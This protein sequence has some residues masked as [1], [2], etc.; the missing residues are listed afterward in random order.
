MATIPCSEDLI[1]WSDGTHCYRYE[2]AEYTFM[3]DD[4]TIIPFD[5]HS[6]VETDAFAHDF[7]AKQSVAFA[8]V[9]V[10]TN[11]Q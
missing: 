8:A 10:P 11:L 3:S 1:V 4:F 7:A 2:L 6:H 9:F 5:E